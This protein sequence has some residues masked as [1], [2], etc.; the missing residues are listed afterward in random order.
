MKMLVLYVMNQVSFDTFSL[1]EVYT[2]Y[3]YTVGCIEGDIRLA[4]GTNVYKG[5]VE[6]C[7]K[8]VWG[9][10]CDDGWDRNAGIVACRQLGLTF[11]RIV[12]TLRGSGQIWLDNLSCSGTETR[13]IDCEHNGFGFHNCIHANDAGLICS[14]K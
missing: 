14:G 13:L 3:F 7:H 2:E 11:S 6:V 9:T 4:N 10:V 8:S 1:I 5:R 12:R